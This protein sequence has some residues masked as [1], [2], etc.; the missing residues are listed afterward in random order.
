MNLYYYPLL[1]LFLSLFP[2]LLH[3]CYFLS[4]FSVTDRTDP[5]RICSI[6]DNWRMASCLRRLLCHWLN[7]LSEFIQSMANGGKIH[8]Y[9]P[10]PV[11]HRTEPFRIRSVRGATHV[12]APYIAS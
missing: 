5:F 12:S 6:S 8:G 3:N 9:I 2:Y 11:I 4:L 10:L 1:C 7:E